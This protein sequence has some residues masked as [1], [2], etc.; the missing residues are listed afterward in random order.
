MKLNVTVVI[1]FVFPL[2]AHSQSIERQVVASTGNFVQNT[3][4][5]LSFTIGEPTIV[6]GTDGSKSLLQ[7]FQ[8]PTYSPR[9]AIFQND[10][11][12][13]CKFLLFPNPIAQTVSVETSIQD[14]AFEIFDTNGKSYG[15]FNKSNG[16]INVSD[17]TTGIYFVKVNCIS[18]KVFYR[19]LI[20]L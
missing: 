4:G 20:K 18:N 10:A 11:E 3:E 9:T 2:L 12:E 7:G 6:L 16:V 8:Q 13:G 17:L 5:S 14:E 1:F 15:Y 19:K